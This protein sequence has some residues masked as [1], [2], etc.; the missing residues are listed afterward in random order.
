[1]LIG[2]VGLF[3][4]GKD[5][6]GNYVSEKYNYTKKDFGQVIRKEMKSLQKNYL[7]RK[8]MLIFANEMRK[9]F[10]PNYWA[11]KLLEDYSHDKKFVISSIRNVKEAKEFKERGAV[12]IC[13]NVN[14][15]TRFKRLLEREKQT[16][17]PTQKTFE[18]FV[19]REALELNDPDPN[20][21]QI[22]KVIELCDKSISNDSTKEELFKQIDG[23]MVNI[24]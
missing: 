10:G 23:L 1:M 19:K 3:G 20:K 21:L 16:G 2:V 12:L 5:T 9:E 13:V 22:S 6:V 17:R 24:S 15:E 4:S 7:D 14:Q 8:E 11:K 18:E